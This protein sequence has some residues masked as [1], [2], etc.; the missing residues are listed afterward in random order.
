M[1][2]QDIP[3][4]GREPAQ[5]MAVRGVRLGLKRLDI[6]GQ[7]GIRPEFPLF[8]EEEGFAVYFAVEF[9]EYVLSIME[10]PHPFGRDSSISKAPAQTQEQ[11]RGYESAQ[12]FILLK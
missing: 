2:G 4:P 7:L 5:E 8:V 12:A 1:M 11:G 6:G 3:G 10:E 9:T